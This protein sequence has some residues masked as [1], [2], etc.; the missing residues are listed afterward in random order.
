[1]AAAMPA[2]ACA[3]VAVFGASWAA[4]GSALFN[5]SVALGS[6]LASA[7]FDVVSGGYGGTM[8]GVSAGAA[9]GGARAT[10]VL[11]PSLFPARDARGNAHL[12]HVVAAPTLLA[13]ID[14]MFSAAPRFSVA[15]PGT[16]GTLTELLC[17]WNTAT[18]APLRGA[19]PP[20]IVAWRAPWEVVLG[21]ASDELGL[22]A[23]VRAAV[24]FVDTVEEAV[25][26]L[27]A[28][29]ARE[30]AGGT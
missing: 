15:L 27:V 12:T 25:A 7:G 13:R 20:T 19:P 29:L 30:G 21:A 24:V 16:L 14:A 18:L 28:A 9:G 3:A 17:A 1:M 8:E 11:V 22:P 4:P 26:T 6:A 10:G 2:P 5:E 23:D